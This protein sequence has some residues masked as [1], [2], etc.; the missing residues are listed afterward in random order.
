MVR[1]RKSALRTPNNNETSSSSGSSE[2]SF[3]SRTFKLLSVWKTAVG[4]A[5]FLIAVYV[6]TLGYLET[7]VNT[8]FDDEKVSKIN[9]LLHVCLHIF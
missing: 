4:F 5:C 2:S 6:S 3:G 7:R 1:Q 9:I 8:P